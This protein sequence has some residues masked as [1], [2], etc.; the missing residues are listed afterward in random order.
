MRYYKLDTL[1]DTRDRDLCLLE[2]EP[3]DMGLEGYYLAMGKPARDHIPADLSI[4][5]SED[6]PG[7]VTAS[8]I[9]NFNNYLLVSTAMKEIIEQHC[10]GL[11]IEY[12]QFA[13]INHKGRVH[14]RDYWIVNPI[15]A[16]D[17]LDFGA[18]KIKYSG[19][20]IVSIKER[21]LSAAK[22]AGAPS[23]FR[24]AR[25]VQTYVVAEPLAEAFRAEGF[26][27]VVLK[28]MKVV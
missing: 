22:L 28:E 1:G 26:T 9:G 13:L 12:F 23:L 20:D 15:G 2:D 5:M 6:Y 10:A 3:K 16:Y 17:C 24:I 11:D 18:S 19:S 8:L 14:T 7:I 25:D 4:S 21:V 27:N